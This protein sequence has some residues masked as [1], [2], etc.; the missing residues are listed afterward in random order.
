[1]DEER[2]GLATAS[3]K[4]DFGGEVGGEPKGVCSEGDKGTAAMEASGEEG[5]N[6]S[7]S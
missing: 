6:G 5:V 4:A 3:E 1:M 7:L 2:G